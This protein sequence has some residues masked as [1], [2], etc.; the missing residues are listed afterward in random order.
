MDT[1]RV[2]HWGSSL[3]GEAIVGG[4]IGDEGEAA[5]SRAQSLTAPAAC[6]IEIA[7][8]RSTARLREPCAYLI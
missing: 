6:L 4:Q 3:T 8:S 5:E 2:D 7:R 1:G